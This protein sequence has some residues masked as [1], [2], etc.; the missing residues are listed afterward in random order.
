MKKSDNLIYLDNAATTFPPPE[1]IEAVAKTMRELPQNPASPYAIASFAR[2]EVRRVKTLLAGIIGATPQGIF[3]TS[4]GSESNN[5]AIFQAAGQPVVISAIEH[6]SVLLAAENFGCKVTQVHAEPSG[7][8]SPD[9]IEAAIRTDTSLV[10]VQLVNNETGVVQPIEEIGKVCKKH[11]VLL[12]CDAV[13]AFGHIPIDV[14]TLGVD[15]L[16]VSAHKIGGPQGIGFLYIK[17]GTPIK[18]LIA[19]GD[20]EKRGGTENLPGIVGFGVAAEIAAAEMDSEDIRLRGL[21]KNFLERL[22]KSL[23]SETVS[24]ENEIAYPGI[25]SLRLC[26]IQSEITIAKLDMCGIMVSGGAACNSSSGKPS[27]VLLSM[28]MTEKQSKEVI[29]ISMGRQTT[30]A[31]MIRTAEVINKIAE[32]NQ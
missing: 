26:G 29:R 18:P 11:K 15:I 23:I 30:E 22:N 21:R 32:E 25:I 31:E 7:N 16:S 3:F 19:G 8:I 10:S 9:K 13:A 2:A 5:W 24:S 1:V 12:H 27:R 20:Y 17:Q 4:G 14:K 28:G 6:A